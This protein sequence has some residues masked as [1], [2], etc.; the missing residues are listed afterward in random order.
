MTT[1]NDDNGAEE[2]RAQY[3]RELGEALLAG[4][5]ESERRQQAKFGELLDRALAA[6]YGPTDDNE[7]TR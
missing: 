2:E 6:R 5:R 7:E 3:R 4:L 1:S